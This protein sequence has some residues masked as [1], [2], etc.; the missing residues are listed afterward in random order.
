[1]LRPAGSAAGTA[2]QVLSAGDMVLQR[3]RVIVVGGCRAL[4]AARQTPHVHTKL[5]FAATFRFTIEGACL[6]QRT[7]GTATHVIAHVRLVAVP[8]GGGGGEDSAACATAA[9][10]LPT[11]PARRLQRRGAS[12]L[13]PLALQPAQQRPRLTD[14]RRTQVHTSNGVQS[15][16]APLVL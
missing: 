4:P 9:G 10:R 5:L 6:Q 2:A 16:C 14:G 1:M 12:L 7:A 13:P 3:M 11:P 15:A 8:R